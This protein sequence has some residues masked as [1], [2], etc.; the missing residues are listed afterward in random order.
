MH[1]DA[2]RQRV[3]PHRGTLGGIQTSEDISWHDVAI[4]FVPG[5]HVHDAKWLAVRRHGPPQPDRLVHA[6]RAL[7]MK[8]RIRVGSLTPRARSTPDDTSTAAAPAMRIASATLYGV[9]PPA[10]SHG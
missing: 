9:R 7:A 3:A 6:A 2:P 4:G 1:D 10:S 8:T 5:P